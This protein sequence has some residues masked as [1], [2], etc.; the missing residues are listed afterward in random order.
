MTEDRNGSRAELSRRRLLRT[1][2][3]AGTA[4]TAGCLGG[5]TDGE[6]TVYGFN[7][8][9][10][11]VSLTDP[12]DDAVVTTT[13][14][15]ATSSFPSNQ[16]TPRLADDG[17]EVLWLNVGEGVR[18]ATVGSLE[19]VAEVETGSGANWL[20]RTPDGEHLVVSA[21]EP[22][23][24]NLRIDADPDSERFGE[25]TGEIDRTDEPAVGDRDGVG[26]CDVSID[27]EG[28]YAFVPDLYGDTLTVLS[29]DSFEIVTQVEVD[30]VGD[31]EHAR[32]WMGTAGWHG[33]VLMIENDEGERGTESIWDVSDPGAPEEVVRLTTEDGL[34]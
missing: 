24:R 3:A 19:T 28:E 9:D 12:A 31:A 6:D 27:P 20:E 1:S 2:A 29:V 23:H 8:G 34:G 21:R 30:A 13:H 14:L 4:A 25:V 7:T 33:E 5:G 10:M 26:P 22:A 18:A 11:T 32:P 15:G 16:Y 17:E